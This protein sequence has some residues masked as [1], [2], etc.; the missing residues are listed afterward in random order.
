MFF[1]QGKLE[2]ITGA[3]CGSMKIEVFG[4]DDRLVC[5]LTDN[6]SMLG[7]F[8]IDDGMRLHVSEIVIP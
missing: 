4:K 6:D 1:N 2:V 8:Q 7:S 3:A 5:T